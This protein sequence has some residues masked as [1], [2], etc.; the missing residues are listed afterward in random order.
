MLRVQDP[1]VPINQERVRLSSRQHCRSILLSRLSWPINLRLSECK[2]E[3][4]GSCWMI[5]SSQLHLRMREGIWSRR[6]RLRRLL[7]GWRI[8]LI[9][10]LM[11]RIKLLM[12]SR[13]LQI[14]RILTWE[15][16]LIGCSLFGHFPSLAKNVNNLTADLSRV[17]LPGIKAIYY[18]AI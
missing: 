11:Q 8:R 4:R 17:T 12:I 16:R 15:R 5:I 2:W 13:L 10:R 6:V 9:R 3:S 14:T 1:Q 18:W 7:R